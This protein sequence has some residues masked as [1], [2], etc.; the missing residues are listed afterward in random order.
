M[1]TIT[2]Q[3]LTL[4]DSSGNSRTTSSEKLIP[5]GGTLQAT[6]KQVSQDQLSPNVFR[7]KLEA[8]S[9]LMEL[10]VQQPITQGSQVTLARSTEGQLSVTI[11]AKNTAK[12]DNSNGA[13]KPQNN[14]TYQTT[15]T[16][17][18]RTADDSSRLNRLIP[19][20]QTIS[21]QVVTQTPGQTIPTLQ[22]QTLT[23][24]TNG[25]LQTSAQPQTTLSQQAQPPL[26]ANTPLQTVAP[27]TAPNPTVPSPGMPSQTIP[28]QSPTVPA[29]TPAQASATPLPLATT[30]QTTQTTTTTAAATPTTPAASQ[31]PLTSQPTQT[32]QTASQT[33]TTA[34]APSSAQPAPVATAS[35]AVTT[36]VN[37]PVTTTAPTQ[38]PLVNQ[39]SLT[40]LTTPSQP[41]PAATK[42]S[43]DPAA[44]IMTLKITGETVSLKTSANLP[45]LQQVQVS[46]STND[47]LLIRWSQPISSP[48]TTAALTLTSSQ[49]QTVENSMRE[50]LPQQITLTSGVQQILNSTQASTAVAAGQIDK[51]VQ[52]LMLL[53]GVQPGA[54]EAQQ[55]IKQNIGYGGLFTEN[56]LANNQAPAK[57]MKQFLGKMQA[58]AEQLPDAQKQVIQTTI[59]KM[60]AR[61]TSN[62]LH[63]LQHRQ[64]KVET[65]ERF[66][67]LDLPVQNQN[68]L[69]NV[70]LRISQRSQKNSREEPETIWKVRLHFDLE[71]SGSIDAE[72]SLNQ[73][74][75]EISAAFTCANKDTAS[76]VRSQLESFKT[77]LTALGLTVPALACRQGEQG[78]QQSPLQKQLIDIKT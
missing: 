62:Q 59:E 63:S 1:S 73:E 38:A 10:K 41:Q 60:L 7:L 5:A 43:A 76:F 45:P 35:A 31:T 70:E 39:T 51:V 28:S 47:Q 52:S 2:P 19:T 54:A 36:H 3:S 46:R 27:Q 57:D 72:L 50:L 15:A 74:Q 13:D 40:T 55:A 44:N 21:A 11:H 34:Q 12:T 49:T 42:Y 24:Q 66:F 48:P 6:V 32:P 14:R 29:Q 22:S 53:F 77:Q 4:L 25:P 64:E 71:E 9:V 16:P 30:S 26:L 33:A 8:N 68:S 78:P 67:Q 75:N 61:I 69:E 37:T 23:P 58:L 18:I 56:K 65:N 20:G 17:V